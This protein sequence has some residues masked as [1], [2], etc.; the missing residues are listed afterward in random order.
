VGPL[1]VA[2]EAADALEHRVLAGRVGFQGAPLVHHAQSVHQDLLGGKQLRGIARVLHGLGAEV[3]GAGMPAQQR[4]DRLLGEELLGLLHL[5]G[6]EIGETDQQPLEGLGR[7]CRRALD[8]DQPIRGE[9]PRAHQH[10]AE[11][12]VLAGT[13]RGGPD[14][15]PVLEGHRDPVPFA[16]D[17]EPA[18]LA[19]LTDQLEDLADAEV[20]QV[21]VERDGHERSRS[22]RATAVEAT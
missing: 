5:L 11:R 15:G 2:L 17:L 22:S 4:E 8:L 20:A 13:H 6:R 10:V 9:E 1:P 7:R 14:H 3:E 12:G 16:L 21:A 18:G 19:L